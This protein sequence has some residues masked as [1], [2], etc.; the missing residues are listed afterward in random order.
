MDLDVATL[1]AL[2]AFIVPMCFTP[3]PNNV[4]CAAHGS[5]H[6]VRNTLPLIAGMAVGWSILGVGIA[7]SI[8][9]LEENEAVL[10]I[11]SYLGAVYIAYL[12]YRVATSS[13]IEGDEGG[14][15]MLG[16]WTGFGLQIVN[17]KAWIHFL[18][19]MTAF[20][21]TFGTEFEGKILLV[22]LNLSFGVMAVLSWATFGTLLRKLFGGGESGIWLNRVLGLLL[23]LVAIWI[24][25][26]HE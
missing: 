2:L 17:G 18:V 16:P 21:T 8:A 1:L 11:M 23:F 26:P 15:E 19:M 12:G 5:L 3:G 25:L 4:L 6:G 13:V 9:F 10:Q 22:L 14:K 24:A 7:A 20:G